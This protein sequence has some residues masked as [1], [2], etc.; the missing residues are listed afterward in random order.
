MYV[1]FTE[2][3]MKKPHILELKKKSKAKSNVRMQCKN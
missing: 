2:L 3:N 1:L